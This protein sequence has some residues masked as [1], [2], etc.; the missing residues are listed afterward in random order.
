MKNEV[1]PKQFDNNAG[2]EIPSDMNALL[3]K[4]IEGDVTEEE[5]V[6][7]VNWM[8]SDAE[9]MKE[10]LAVRKL[11]DITLWQTSPEVKMAQQP[12]QKK[13][14][15][16]GKHIYMEVLK[17]AAILLVAIF[18]GRYAFP[19]LKTQDPVVM[20]TLHVPAGQRAEITLEDGTKV[21]LNAKT[22][23]TFPN[24]FSDQAREVRID[25]EGFFDVTVNKKKPFIVKTV[26]YDIKV[27]GTQFNLLA[28]STKG[29]FETSLLEGSV[30]V[31]KSGN[32][33]GMLMNVGERIFQENNQLVKA[34]IINPNHF[35]WKEGIISFNNE[36]FP[37]LIKKLELYFD[38]KVEIKNASIL[39]YKCTGKFRTKDG[40]EHI[41]KVLQLSNKFSFKKDDKTNTIT[42][43]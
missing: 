29:V 13:S 18:I 17:I 42:I 30:E 37:E 23:L 7:I 43:E 12:K 36:S 3:L 24:R 25:G 9:H 32:S 6:S 41:L 21:W 33:K 11:Y 1:L 31:I 40:V 2:K 22:T 8:D 28:Y 20:Q 27:W 34:S 4:Y 14:T 26:G 35:L 10:Y 16:W 39:K 19:E 38:L 5:K 15:R